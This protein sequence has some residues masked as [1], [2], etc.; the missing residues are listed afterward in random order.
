MSAR[1]QLLTIGEVA[2]R[3]GVRTSTLR[4]YEDEGLLRPVTRVGGQRRYDERA[5]EALTVIRFAI[6]LLLRP[7]S[8]Y[9]MASRSRRVSL[10]CWDASDKG[11]NAA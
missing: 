5:V 1:D 11:I 3:A 10:N 2:A 8:K 6:S 7:S 9:A 4:Y